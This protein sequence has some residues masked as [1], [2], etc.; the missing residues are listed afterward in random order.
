MSSL[1]S[2]QALVTFS[3]VAAYF[4]EVEW[5]VLGEW[6]KNLYKKVIK[7]IHGILIS[8]GYSIV[9][10]DVIFKIKKEDEKY[11]TQ[12]YE[13]ERKENLN[14]HTL[15][16]PIVTSVF[17]LT[18]KQ[19]EDLPFMNHAESETAEEIHPPITGSPSVKPDIL[20]RFKQEGVRI[21]TP[22]FED[23][24]NLTITGPCEELHKADDGFRNNS[25]RQKMCEGHQKEERKH[26]DSSS[27]YPDT[28]ADCEG[29]ISRVT[30]PTVKDKAQKAKKLNV[31]P[32]Q[33]RSSNHYPNL[34]QTQRL[35]EEDSLFKSADTWEN[36]ITNSHFTDYQEMIVC[37]N[38]FT[39]NSSHTCIPQYHRKEKKC[40][41]PE[42]DKTLTRKS[43]L[44]A[45]KKI[46]KQDQP[47][48]CTDSKKRFTCRAQFTV[49]QK[50]HK[51]Q[52]LF[53]CSECDKSFKQKSGLRSHKKTHTGE[54]PFKCTECDKCFSQKGHLQ[55]HELVHT[56]EKPFKCSEC[57][58]CFSRK[59]HLQQHE[60]THMRQKPFKCSECDKTFSQKSGLKNH[61]KN[62]TGEKLFKCSECDKCFS[63]KDH[64]QQHGMIHI[65]EKPF[66]C[67]ECGKGFCQKSGLRIHEKFHTGE[68]P[69]KCSQCDKGFSQKSVLRNHE[70]IHTGEKPFK[71][72]EC[73]KCFS[74]NGHLQQHRMVHM[75]RKPFKCSECDKMF[76]QKSVLSRHQTIHTREQGLTI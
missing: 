14:D 64:L 4:L 36:L 13:W 28:S 62:H 74:R 46:H 24:G 5:D 41:C 55:Q 48:K 6:Q 47:F 68:K 31:C 19:E 8:R 73:D 15:S 59:G 34:V 71:C 50:F 33:E 56:Q 9:N 35:D 29:G 32:E 72:S 21:R 22:V 43:N 11:S 61:I 23:R 2:D 17:S 51:E 26:R 30:L 38:M 20:I 25:K 58:K 52:E 12:H 70:K 45:Y 18:V 63:R 42:S 65:R 60:M 57:E 3:D 7:E 69:F 53:T 27:D 1:V 16:L 54:K 10:P 76:S 44:P 66:K 37:G 40:A 49:H 39:E 75:A 67:S